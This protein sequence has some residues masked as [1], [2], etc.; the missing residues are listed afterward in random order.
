MVNNNTIIA[1]VFLYLFVDIL[2]VYMS[3][4]YYNSKV[5]K[6]QGKPMTLNNYKYLSALISYIILGVVWYY[7]IGTYITKEKT[8]IEVIQ[9]GLLIAL[10]IYGVFNT[11]LFVMFDGWDIYITIRDTLWGITWICLSAVLYYLYIKSQK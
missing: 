1:F 3:R 8:F 11:T 6:I 5:K 2:Y 9:R 10:A 4:D 7:L